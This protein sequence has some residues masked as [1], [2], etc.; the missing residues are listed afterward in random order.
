[1]NEQ[2]LTPHEH[3][4]LRARLISGTHR[5]RPIGKHRKG[6]LVGASALAAVAI[7][8]IGSISA[9]TLFGI[10]MPEPVS[11]P[12]PTASSSPT[13]IPSPSPTPTASE[14]ATR[15]A[16]VPFDGDCS[17]TLDPAVIERVVGTA[18]YE[19]VDRPFVL[20]SSGRAEI[21]GGL[22]CSWATST[23]GNGR[24]IEISI[25]PASVVTPEV[26]E[27]WSELRA[28]GMGY[29]Y[30]K[31]RRVGDLMIGATVTPIDLAGIEPTE[32]ELTAMDG[33]VDELIDEVSRRAQNE[34]AEA[35][36]HDG[37]WWALRT[38]AD[39]ADAVQA[40]LSMQLIAGFPGDSIPAGMVWETMVGA[41]AEDWCSWYAVGEERS[42]VVEFYLQPGAG[43][44]TAAQIASSGA[45]P[46]QVAG[47]DGSWISRESPQSDSY[48]LLAVS[49]PNRLSMRFVRAESAAEVEAMAAAL[50]TRL[51]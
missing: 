8:A 4:E 33:R 37:S 44:P 49:G 28:E 29:Y 45:T 21:I 40:Q 1:M 12:T 23:D 16:V 51:G 27:A 7:I 3:A 19:P 34:R 39:L 48:Q 14:P 9:A 26:S 10:R 25:F 22:A 20:F 24:V 15:A 38:C 30:E 17:A 13:S 50:L 35:P 43:M 46:A 42:V 41:K 18:A 31:Q 11:T 36:V 6:M 47:A 2:E 5:I 32:A